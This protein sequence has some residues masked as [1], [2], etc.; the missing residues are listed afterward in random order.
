MWEPD[1][2]V[3]TLLGKI[4]STIIGGEVGSEDLIFHC[5]DGTK[6]HLYHDQD[7]CESVNIEDICGDINDLIGNPILQAEESTSTEN[8]E[9]VKSGD[10][11]SF[12]WTFY[13]FAT[14]KGYITIR[15]YGVSNG[16]YSESVDFSEITSL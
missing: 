5:T 14:D 3:T 7:C 11:N 1:I 8:P 13:K 15:W 9:G 4:I 12:K 10:Q 6:F 16:C 2:E